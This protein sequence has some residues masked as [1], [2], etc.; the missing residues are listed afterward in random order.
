MIMK[1]L[2]YVFLLIF[3]LFIFSGCTKPIKYDAAE[4]V[5]HQVANNLESIENIQ[6]VKEETIKALSVITRTNL[7]QEDNDFSENSS[8][9]YSE[10]H[11][12]LYNISNKTAGEVLFDGENLANI[13]ILQTNNSEWE[14]E[15]KKSTLL[16]FLSENNI[17]LSNISNIEPNLDDNG[18]L[19]N[20]NIGGKIINY[21]SL[22]K[23]FNLKSNKITKID[24]TISSIIIHGENIPS[25]TT[26]FIDEAEKLAAEGKNY[27]ELLNHFFNGFDLKTTTK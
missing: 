27:K 16:S 8:K 13:E 21:D 14:S 24:N 15:I 3:T 12:K 1:R 17:S 19:V 7:L 23:N 9:T 18:N 6:N 4:S 25:S 20:L 22:E 11:K 2:T 10:E 26:F 5:E